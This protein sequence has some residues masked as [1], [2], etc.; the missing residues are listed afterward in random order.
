MSADVG[1]ASF[2]LYVVR[3]ANIRTERR[4]FCSKLHTVHINHF[5]LHRS[6]IRQYLGS[7][8]S[9]FCFLASNGCKVIWCLLNCTTMSNHVQTLLHF[10]R[11]SLPV[12]V[13]L[14]FKSQVEVGEFQVRNDG[15]NLQFLAGD[16]T[17]HLINF[18]QDCICWS[19]TLAGC[20][21]MPEPPDQ[22]NTWGT[23]LFYHE[24][25]L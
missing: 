2:V 14:L 3:S 1:L 16:Y 19:L 7:K 11:I 18:A 4:F 24:I 25:W 8:P 12:L 17:E 20:W 13:Q 6:W 9:H 23:L 10:T 5:S 22:Y 15:R 21:M